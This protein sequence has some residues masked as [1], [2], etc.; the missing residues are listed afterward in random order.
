MC[1]NQRENL[2]ITDIRKIQ[3][4]SSKLIHTGPKNPSNPVRTYS[5]SPIGLPSLLKG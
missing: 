1:D 2:Q 4:L 5:L 3:T